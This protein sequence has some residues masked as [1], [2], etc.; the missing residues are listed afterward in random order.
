MAKRDCFVLMPTGGG[1]C[2]VRGAACECV[3]LAQANRSVISCQQWPM[4]VTTILDQNGTRTRA[5][6]G[7]VFD[8]PT[9]TRTHADA[10]AAASLSSCRR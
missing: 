7:V 5:V 2:D 1:E 3:L 9:T 4:D 8:W 6:R 10:A